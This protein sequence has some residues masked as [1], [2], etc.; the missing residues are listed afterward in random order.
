MRFV[1]AVEKTIIPARGFEEIEMSIPGFTAEVTLYHSVT[2]YR[3]SSSAHTEMGLNVA[4]Q[5]PLNWFEVQC[6]S[7]CYHRFMH[8]RNVALLHECLADC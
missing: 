3:S 5:F 8:D 2:S 1:P 6:R 4:P 7:G